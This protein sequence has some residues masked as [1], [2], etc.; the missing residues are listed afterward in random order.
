MPELQHCPR[1]EAPLP[2]DAPSG[3]CPRC[4]FEV[5]FESGVSLPEDSRCTGTAS[6]S[7]PPAPENLAE[8]F[9]HFE[10]IE[11]IGQGGMGAI[12]KARQR[13]LD[14]YAMG[15]LLYEML[16]GEL[17]LGRFEPPSQK[18]T[19]DPRLDEVVMRAMQTDPENRYQTAAE[20]RRE[21][22]H[23]AGGSKVPLR[24]VPELPRRVR[25]INFWK[26]IRDTWT[27][28]W[29]SVR[30]TWISFWQWVG[31]LPWLTIG[32]A[33]LVWVLSMEPTPWCWG[34]QDEADS[35]SRPAE[36]SYPTHICRYR[37]RAQCW[38]LLP[39]LHPDADQRISLTHEYACG[40]SRKK[41]SDDGRLAIHGVAPGEYDLVIQLLPRRHSGRTS[42]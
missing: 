33:I 32:A 26:P 19:L 9:P 41:L 31:T 22:E 3:T 12:Y 36:I 16:T 5:G 20:M 34:T 35:P 42:S 18:A 38:Q 28:A 1:C 6:Q 25:S 21:V 14:R 10:I 11:L 7:T 37:G 39:F 17:P 2:A 8:K 4:F 13:K 24:I 30:R 29:K 23:I 27:G 40:A 15:V